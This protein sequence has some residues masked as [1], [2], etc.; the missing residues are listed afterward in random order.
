[1][2]EMTSCEGLLDVGNAPAFVY[3]CLGCR[4]KIR[5]QNLL[6]RMDDLQTLILPIPQT[7]LGE[8]ALG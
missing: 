4:A 1:M 5:T 3:T 6:V 8:L 2:V 7:T